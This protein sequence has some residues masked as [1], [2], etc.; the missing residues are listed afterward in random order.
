MTR[1]DMLAYAASLFATM[2]IATAVPIDDTPAGLK[3][4]LDAAEDALGDAAGSPDNDEAAR[5]LIEYYALYKFRAAA[6][7]RPDYDATAMRRGRGQLYE[8]IDDMIN[9]AAAAATA[10]GHPVTAAGGAYGIKAINLEYL[11]TESGLLG[12]ELY[13]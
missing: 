12:P 6:A 11:D 3:Y 7:A 4:Q 13:A 5:P 2:S 9:Q 1:A 10:A 8:Q